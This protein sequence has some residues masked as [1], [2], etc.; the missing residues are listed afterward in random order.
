MGGTAIVVGSI[1]GVGIVL[2][3]PVVA[4]HSGSV[5][6]YLALWLFGGLVAF[7]GASAYAEL[8]TRFPEAGGD[9]VYIREAFGPSAA[10]AAGWLLVVGVFTGSIATLAAALVELQLPALLGVAAP[11]AGVAALV[12]IA[13]LTALNLLGTRFSTG[14]Q[15]LL[16][17]APILLLGVGGIVVVALAAGGHLPAGGGEVLVHAPPGGGSAV[18]GF[19]AVYFAYSGWNAVAYMAGDMRDPERTIPRALF[20]GTA[21][22]TGLY[23]LLALAFLLVLGIGGLAAAGD[24]GTEATRQLTGD[25]WALGV[26]VAVTLALL[27]ALNATILT[28]SRVASA[29]APRGLAPSGSRRIRLTLLAQGVLAGLLVLTGTFERLLELTSLAMLLLGGLVALSHL[30]IRKGDGAPGSN[31]S[32]ERGATWQGDAAAPPFRAP[33]RAPFHPVPTLFFFCV[34][35]GVLVLAAGDAFA[36]PPGSWT[37]EAALPLLGLGVFFLLWLG[38]GLGRAS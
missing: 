9:Y 5:A 28:G 18:R 1:L 35:L 30:R 17:A 12:P 23:V 29:V 8:G 7:C 3:P 32:G 4:A 36:R 24:A 37:V 11:H 2:V 13:L 19:L 27:G 16:V 38:H 31:V 14:S 15:I 21:L 22:M 6:V 25:G 33:F 20:W 26:G 10:F 34:S